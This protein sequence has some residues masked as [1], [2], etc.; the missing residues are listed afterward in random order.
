MAVNPAARSKLPYDPADLA[1]VILFGFLSAGI[2]VH[3][4]VPANSWQELL[5]LAKAKPGGVV[6]GSYGATSASTIFIE[7]LKK[8]QGIEFLNVPYKAASLAWPA[9]LAGEVQVTYYALTSPA[10]QMVK[11]GKARTLVTAAEQRFAALP[12]VPTYKELGLPFSAATWFGLCAPAKTPRDI[13]QR[14]NAVVAQGLIRDQPTRA[15]F[16]ASQGIEPDP[17]AG[18]PP[19]SF[20][21]VIAT[22]QKTYA[23]LVK[24]TGIKEE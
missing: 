11:A 13:V 19:E 12:D 17:P 4:S 23:Q 10:V 3:P 14:L 20:A 18:G 15:K 1:P 16:L 24:L 8:T 9:M 7:W 5:A 6:W 2:H 22:E 21:Q